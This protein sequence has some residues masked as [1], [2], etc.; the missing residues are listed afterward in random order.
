MALRGVCVW[1]CSSFFSRTSPLYFQ[2]HWQPGTSSSVTSSQRWWF[3]LTL[4]FYH[5]LPLTTFQPHG[6][7]FQTFGSLSRLKVS[8]YTVSSFWNVLHP[9]NIGMVGSSYLL[10]FIQVFAIILS[11]IATPVTITTQCFFIFIVNIEIYNHLF[12]YCQFLPLEYKLY[13]KRNLVWNDHRQLYPQPTIDSSMKNYY[14]R[15]SWLYTFIV[16]I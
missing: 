2:P 3:V 13:E 12:I 5:C 4:I 16:S 7:S 1:I 14:W 15:F 6:P 10:R 8:V 9:L 11:Q